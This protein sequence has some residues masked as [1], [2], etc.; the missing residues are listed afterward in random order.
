[1][2]KGKYNKE[3]IEKLKKLYLGEKLSLDK[4]A[5]K[6]NCPQGSMRWLLRKYKIPIRG[7]KEASRLNHWWVGRHHTKKTIRK[8]RKSSLGKPGTTNGRHR[9]E[10]EKKSMG[11]K[12]KIIMKLKWQNPEY[13][14]KA[15]KSWRRN[16]N[17]QE[18][19]L[20]TILQ[21][22]F[23]NEYK[24]NTK[25][26]VMVLGGKVPDFV[27]VNG[28]KKIVELYGDYFHSRR[29]AERCNKE[30]KPPQDRIDYFKKLGWDTIVIWGKELKDTQNLESKL[31]EFN[32]R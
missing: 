11:K 31:L 25:G 14:A 17:K 22:L 26:K 9:T 10:A 20:N 24:M 8:M 27:N 12:L 30:F 3:F 32:D 13:V 1:M 18:R 7:V 4:V 2:M 5:K 19:K 15:L 29:F 6:L 23:P 28:Q 16:P 21:N